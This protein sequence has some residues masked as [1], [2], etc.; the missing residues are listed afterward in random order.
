[1]ASNEEDFFMM[2]QNNVK[3]R[4]SSPYHRAQH[5][6]DATAGQI[7]ENVSHLRC[8]DILDHFSFV[9]R[10]LTASYE[11][12]FFMMTGFQKIELFWGQML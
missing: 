9:C 1:M 5:L 3:F 10:A 12:D 6:N 11:E 8:I 7:A 4:D 2:T